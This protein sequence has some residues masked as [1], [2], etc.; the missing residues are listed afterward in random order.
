MKLI[1]HFILVD[2]DLL[3]QY[4]IALSNNYFFIAEQTILE[5]S[6]LASFV[7]IQAAGPRQLLSITIRSF[8]VDQRESVDSNPVFVPSPLWASPHLNNLNSQ[9]QPLSSVCPPPVLCCAERV[10]E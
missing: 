1:S 3:E 5:A 4:C 8:S 2:N 7:S 9:Q 6:A 10:V